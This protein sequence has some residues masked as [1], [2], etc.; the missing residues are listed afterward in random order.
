MS[1]PETWSSSLAAAR[2]DGLRPLGLDASD[3]PPV[4]DDGGHVSRGLVVALGAALI[5][6][7]A[8]SAAWAWRVRLNAPYADDHD[9]MDLAVRQGAT[10]TAG[11]LLQPHNN[12]HIVW[13][14]LLAWVGRNG[15][16][17]SVF[18]AAG[19]GLWLASALALVG[20]AVRLSPTKARGWAFGVLAALIVTETVAVQDAAWPVFSV[21]VFVAAFAVLALGSFELRE[22]AKLGTPAL[23][24][25]FVCAIATGFGNAAGLA[26]WPTLVWAAWRSGERGKVMAAVVLV[27]LC[28]CAFGLEGATTAQGQ[29]AQSQGLDHVA[30]MVAYFGGYCALPWSA[31]A[32]RLLLQASGWGLAIIGLWLLAAPSPEP[33]SGPTLAAYGRALIAFA[34][35]TAAMATVGRVDELAQAIVPAR[36]VVFADLLHVGLLFACAPQLARLW[37]RRPRIAEAAI[38]LAC[39]LMLLQQAAFGRKMAKAADRLNAAGEAFDRGDRSAAVVAL[40]YPPDPARAARIRQT[41]RQKH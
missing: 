31:G 3:P 6:T 7:V 20:F 18:L 12:Q 13:A 30:K 1:A 39:L 5:T 37:A 15:R 32:P 19:V 23:V 24:V 21:Y 29:A 38:V 28:A 16:E 26:V 9:W 40:V 25:A 14:R 33:R 27:G 17:M 11:Y 4:P 41:L 10:L 8:A 2:A 35:T 36:Y 34:L 22:R